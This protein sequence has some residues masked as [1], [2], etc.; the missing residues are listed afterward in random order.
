MK[1]FSRRDLIFTLIAGP[2]LAALLALIGP[3]AWDRGL[4]AYAAILI[5]GIFLLTFTWR[6][7]GGGKTLAALLLGAFLI[8]ILVAVLLT[9]LL[10]MFGYSDSPTQQAGYLYFDAQRRDTQAWQ[11]AQSDAAI[12]S[13]FGKGLVSD[14]YGGLLAL[15]ASVYRYASPDAHRPL[16]VIVVAALFAAL[17]AAFTYRA[18]QKRWGDS[19][20]AS[21]AWIVALFPD[22]VM[23]GSSQMREPFLITFIAMAFHGLTEWQ[24]SHSAR[25]ALWIGLGMLGMLLI[26]PGLILITLIALA[27]WAWFSGDHKQISWKVLAVLIAVFAIGVFA[28]AYAWGGAVATTAGPF[29]VI[30]AWIKEAT[31]WSLHTTRQASGIVQ[32]V[33]ESI[34]SWLH[35]PFLAIY[36]IAQPVLPAALIEDSNS[37]WRVIGV[38]RSLGWYALLP[39]LMYALFAARR[40][41][42]THQRRF[43]LWMFAV[44]WAWVIIASVRGGGDQWDNPRYRDI[45][46]VFQSY[47]AVYAWRQFRASGD[48]WLWRI[49][50]I[51]IVSVLIFTNWYLWRYLDMGFPFGARQTILLALGLAILIP[52]GDWLIERRRDAKHRFP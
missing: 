24:A 23:L 40:N 25:G 39:L 1:G 5:P 8:R 15:S 17:G 38:T 11:L 7:F 9:L 2:V 37:L 48:R 47:L 19:F 22:A 4:L 43:W 45:L 41:A 44:V 42:E 51:E 46:L 35:L 18:A 52:L 30:G 36:G 20:A 49:L 6:K 13:A 12:A 14:Q 50:A 3:G 27:G 34:P 33:F 32:L 31:K 10:P 28:L 29:A 26:S 21:S 16:L